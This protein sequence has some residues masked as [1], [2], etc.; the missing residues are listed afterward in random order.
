[1][2]CPKCKT[3]WPDELKA[4]LKFCGA[5]GA[6]MLDEGAAEAEP[7]PSPIAVAVSKPGGELRFVT[8]LFADLAGFTTFAEDRAPDEVARI[9]GDLLQ[10]LGK[11]V[12]DFSG[13][14]DKFLGDA[15]VAT[16]GLPKPDPN[17]AR[18][19]VRAGLAMQAAARRFNEEYNLSFDLRVGIHAGEVMFRSI[20]GSWTVMGD[21]VNT[22]SR[23]QSTTTPGKVWISRPVFEEVRRFFILLTR[24]AVELKGKKNSVQPYEVVEERITPFVNLPPFVGRENEWAAIQGE[25]KMAVEQNALRVVILRGAAGIGKS[26]LAWELR[27]WI[28]RAPEIYRV[29]LA[30]FDSGERLPSHGLNSMIRSRFN[31]PL[32][33][34]NQAIL[35]RL[36]EGM[37]SENPAA[38]E[39]TDLIVEFFAFVL[40]ISLENFR[41]ANMDMKSRWESVFIE[42]KAWLEYFSHDEPAVWFLEDAQKGD[43]DTAAFLDWA[44]KMEWHA[45]ALFLVT[46]RE[47]DFSPDCYWYPAITRWIN[48]GQV[49]EIRLKEIPPDLLAKAIYDMLD[50]AV[51]P[52]L[53][54]RIAEHTE[55]NPLFATE[56]ALLLKETGQ[57]DSEFEQNRLSLP[58]SIREV[59]EA[60]IERLGQNGKEV[61]KRGS[62][63]GRRFS[64]EAVERTWDHN[65]DELQNG[66][67]ILYET[68]TIYEEESKVYLGKQ[69]DVFRHGRLQEAI[70]ARIP[71][72]ER[73][74]WLREL[75]IWALAKLDE[76]E[77]WAAAA[78]LLI[79]IIIHSR[80]EQYD[81]WQASLWHEVLGLVHL[82]SYRAKEAARAFHNA[83]KEASGTRRLG[84][85]YLA[86]EAEVFGGDGEKAL[87]TVNT[88][89]SDPILPPASTISTVPEKIQTLLNILSSDALAHWQSVSATEAKGALT[90]TQGKVLTNL[91]RVGE[92]RQIF[93]QLGKELS[94]VNNEAGKRLLMRWARAWV[95]LLTELIGNQQEAERACIFLRQYPDLQDP[96]LADE[97]T[98]FLATEES[99]AQ[100]MGRYRQAQELSEKSMQIALA[101]KNLRVQTQ[102]WNNRGIIAHLIGNLDMAADAY[103]RARDISAAIGNRRG[104][105]IAI[106]NL[107]GIYI[108][109]LKL[110]E[111]AQLLDQYQA[112]S[113]ITGNRLAQAYAPLS[114]SSIELERDHFDQAAVFLNQAMTT[115]EQN[116]WPALV[117]Y[118]RTNQATID[119]YRWL[120]KREVDSLERAATTFEN[121]AGSQLEDVENENL[122]FIILVWHY[123]GRTAEAAKAIDMFRTRQDDSWVS[124]H[125]WLEL[126]ENVLK[127][128]PVGKIRQ[129]FHQLGNFRA[130]KL[131]AKIERLNPL[132]S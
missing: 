109:Q 55:G 88:A 28:Q 12:E 91:G 63:I 24:P 62:L 60:R 76:E 72:E 96:A 100:H 113:H 61:A 33:M 124:D 31:L 23:I 127:N 9:V 77:N 126:V 102:I 132:A 4:I 50:Q 79:P 29:N 103:T 80:E 94:A 114:L 36:Y 39:R 105:V 112:L 2:I 38:G 95:Y 10:R 15:V 106:F 54:Q 97:W 22:A 52:E 84:L 46:L 90:L 13:A 85:A 86:A 82:K 34:D 115:A 131:V 45:P 118:C 70:L 8:V 25:L 119:F 1:M 75:E 18:N 51:S 87:L 83:L 7:K 32:E 41:S 26:R 58:G 68:E 37:P 5:C 104:E 43:A 6:S 19:A 69:E 57:L 67:A 48:S 107:A 59:M 66:Y 108:D 42:I 11:V 40:G 30:Q 16:F 93:E 65:P 64:H 129:Q 110:E 121:D 73:L 111:A 27:E 128:Q 130:E 78:A 116:G 101:E 92:A 117:E 49:K 14:V 53:A 74:K 89:L 123:S 125:C 3:A 20:G 81:V 120:D 98:L 122:A 99:V 56:L 71:R 47:E 17:A 21:T 44:L 35:N